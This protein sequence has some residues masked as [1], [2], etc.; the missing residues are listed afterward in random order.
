MFPISYGH[1][2]KNTSP[3]EPL[4]FLEVFKSGKYVDW[5]AT[6]WFVIIFQERLRVLNEDLLA[7]SHL[8][9]LRW[10]LTCWVSRWRQLINLRR[11]SN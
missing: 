8:R 11:R 10:Y 2:M 1:Y 6:Q 4:I 5:S 9:H 3:T 7:G